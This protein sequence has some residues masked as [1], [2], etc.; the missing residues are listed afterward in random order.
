[1]NIESSARRCFSDSKVW[2][3]FIDLALGIS[4][5]RGGNMRDLVV[6]AFAN[7]ADALKTCD[8]L[9]ELKQERLLQLADAVFVSR[10]PD[11]KTKVKQVARLAGGENQG[12]LLD[13]VFWL[14]WQEMA[15]STAPGTQDDLPGYI[16]VDKKFI[17][18]VL[19][20]IKPGRA[21]C[22]LLATNFAEDKVTGQ[23]QDVTVTL[24]KTSLS[25]ENEAT[26]K[27]VFG[28]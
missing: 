4:T 22:F 8:K 20:T 15:T 10:K 21:A 2:K 16:G 7:D 23:L 19:Q 25:K 1:M 9:L 6:L 26:L 27:A 17:K 12:L 5:N 18:E 24:L 11:G 3:I 14:S 13:F 28:R